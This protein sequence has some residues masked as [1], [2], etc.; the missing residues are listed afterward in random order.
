[1]KLKLPFS[2]TFQN[3][4]IEM[5]EKKQLAIALSGWSFSNFR[6]GM[7]KT[8]TSD[9]EKHYLPVDLRG[10]VVL[11]IGAGEGETAMFFLKHG[12]SKVVCVESCPDA[13]TYLAVNQRNH[14]HRITAINSK[15][16]ISQLN[17]PHDFLKMDIEGY[18]EVLLGVKLVTPAA[19][20]VHGLQLSDKFE[21]AGWRIKPMNEE[22]AKGYGCVKYAYWRC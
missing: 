21:A 14:P 18:E 17:N 4:F 20:E 22:C 2:R 19:V 5:Q 9:W 13:Y 8:E 11:D 10:K 3:Y 7:I 12:A 16:Q 6:V 1:M 15:F